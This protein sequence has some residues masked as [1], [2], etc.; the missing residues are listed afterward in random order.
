[1]ENIIENKSLNILF[2]SCD[3]RNIF[4]TDFEEVYKKLERD[5]L[6]PNFNKFFFFSWAN[7]GYYKKRDERFSSIHVKTRWHFFRPIFDFMSIFIV[8]CKV[9]KYGFKPDI[10]LV[11]DFGFLPAAKI[12]KMIFGGKIVLCLTNMPEICS[13]TRNFGGIKFLYSFIIER[14]FRGFIDQA[15]TINETM[16]KYMEI[17]GIKKEKI[18]IFASDTIKRDMIHIN[19]SRKG[20][21]RK[22]YGLSTNQK[23]I[24]SVGR[25]EAEKDF[26]RLFNIFSKLDKNYFLIILGQGSLRGPL[27]KLAIDLDIKNRVIFSG[28]IERNEIWNYYKDADLFMLLSKAEALGLVFWEAM[29]MGVPVIGSTAVGIMESI[30]KNGERGFLVEDEEKIDSIIKKIIFCV[31]DSDEKK[32]MLDGAKSYVVSQIENHTNINDVLKIKV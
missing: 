2:I 19:N 20:V 21:I 6:N 1:M 13:K 12:I 9:F 14:L 7:K 8:P 22:K 5:R 27:E 17:L 10:I 26:P 32:K 11:Y 18:I 29:Y 30:V 15:Y 25:L 28:F 4:E 24:M 16:K 3:W 31:S 23:I